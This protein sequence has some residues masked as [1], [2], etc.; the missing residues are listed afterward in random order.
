[1]VRMQ[2]PNDHVRDA[3][4]P[5]PGAPGEGRVRARPALLWSLVAGAIIALAAG[6][7]STSSQHAPQWTGPKTPAAVSSDPWDFNDKPARTLETTR[8]FNDK[9]ARVLK[10]PHYLIHTTI[11]DEEVLDRLP[12]V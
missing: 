1:M 8:S 6:C 4:S 11:D 3:S 7:A 10:T 12:Q 2:S 5:S 9:S